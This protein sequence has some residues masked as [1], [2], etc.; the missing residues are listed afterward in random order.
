M[1]FYRGKFRPTNIA[2]YDG[3]YTNITYRSS[4]ERQV[5][6]WADTNPNIISY[7]SEETVVPYRCPTDNKQH[8]YFVDLKLKFANGATYLIE[9]KPACQTIEPKKGS[10]TTKRYITEVMS[11][12]KNQAKWSAADIYAK[13]RGMIF[14]V[15]TEKFLTESLGIKLINVSKTKK[16]L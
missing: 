12:V 8:R 6:R 2:K 4:W 15:W 1:K 5:L 10:R 7:S 14:E 13:Q 16:K 11:Y 3:D 9:I